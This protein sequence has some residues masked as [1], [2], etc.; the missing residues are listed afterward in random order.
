MGPKYISTISSLLQATGMIAKT[1]ETKVYYSCGEDMDCE[2]F[3][4]RF[5]FRMDFIHANKLY[6][7]SKSFVQPQ[8]A[9]PIHRDNVSKPLEGEQE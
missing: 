6:V 1:L 3:S 5:P 9:P 4:Y 2:Y 7:R 8:I